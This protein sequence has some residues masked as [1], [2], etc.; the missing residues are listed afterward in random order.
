M[1]R[2]LIDTK[3]KA[4]AKVFPAI[5]VIGPRQSGKTTLIKSIFPKKS[6]VL[7]E[8]PDTL[9]F[10]EKD[11][12]GFL[13]QFPDGAVL[14][15]AHRAP[16]IFSY[17]QG[18]LDK[19]KKAGMFIISGSSNFLLMEKIT[20]SLAGRIAILKLLPF[21]LPELNKAKISYTTP[22]QY[23]F[24][25][26]F[27]RLYDQRV[28]P[29]D[30]FSNY[31]QTYLERDLRLFKNIQNLSVFHT[32]LKMLAHRTGQLLNLSSL[33]YDCG[34]TH[35]TAKA[36][37][38]LLEASFIIF[39]LKP[40]HRNFKK[41]L[42]KMPKV[43][44]CD[45]GLA[46]YLAD[47]RNIEQ[48]QNHPLKGSLFESFVISE[49]LKE[50]FNKGEQPDIY[51]WRDKLGHEIDVIIER[52]KNI[53]AVEIKSGSTITPDYFKNLE[54][55]TKI[56]GKALINNYIV[57]GGDQEQRRSDAQVFAWRNIDKLFN[58]LRQ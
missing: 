52:G 8:D 13:G 2:R 56:T 1:I 53:S 3:L 17:L 41:R 57:Y 22:E 44:F 15:E 38:S 19:Y 25:G 12:R 14:D 27:P 49:L 10:A 11:P 51:F 42:V 58:K 39:I 9:E 43:Y 28:S 54:Y 30:L 6:Y 5:A 24:N 32:F 48:M 34:I 55:L 29:R 23:L 7:L 36:W 26:M 35:N 47:I 31:V 4:L 16:K 18:I 45:T 50:R 37:I 40:F 46:A 20:Q 33:A 21:S